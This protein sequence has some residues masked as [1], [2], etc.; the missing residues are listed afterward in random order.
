MCPNLRATK[1]TKERRRTSHS[2][3]VAGS[4]ASVRITIL[5]V[6]YDA[7]DAQSRRPRPT[8]MASQSIFLK[9]LRIKRSLSKNLRAFKRKLNLNKAQMITSKK[10][11]QLRKLSKMS[12]LDQNALKMIIKL[13]FARSLSL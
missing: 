2:L 6:E 5:Q 12:R 8:S 3:M 10:L 1:Q 7:I 4:A 13:L 11:N 9:N